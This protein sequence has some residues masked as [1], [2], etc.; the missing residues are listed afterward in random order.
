MS[1]HTIDV[2]CGTI[3]YQDT[4]GD[5]PVLVLLHG[6]LMDH[7]L[8][9]DVVRELGEGYRCIVPTLPM[10]GHRHPV[11]DGTDLSLRGL[12]GLVTELLERLDL[13][14]VTLIGNDTGGAL[15]QLVVRQDCPRVSRIV[16]ASCEAF[17]NLPPG[18]T[19]ATLFLTGKLPPVLFGAFMQQLRL[20]P[21][22]RLPISFGWLT[23]A[24]DR[25][26]ERWLEPIFTRA[27][28]RRDVV[29]M[30][31]ATAKDRPVLSEASKGITAFAGPALV[32]WAVGDK[33]M[34]PEHGLRLAE[35]LP[36]GRLVEVSD[37][38]TLIPLDQPARFTAAIEEFLSTSSSGATA[39]E[40]I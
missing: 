14:E 36:Q 35:L 23:K 9:S 37:S 16:L 18:A 27:E 10:G 3:D 2:S 20:K 28:I 19:G 30:L 11:A 33:V 39:S 31:R 15:I 26:V 7:T 5:G 38:Y 24:G 25:V 32:V 13:T 6:M 21:M 12:A 22:R 34:P 40:A 1:H 4:G 8:W 29:R 17:D